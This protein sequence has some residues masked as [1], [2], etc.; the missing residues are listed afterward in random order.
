M[1]VSMRVKW[2]GRSCANSDCLSNDAGADADAEN[3]GGGRLE[4]SV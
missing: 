2:V 3:D 1:V 4:S